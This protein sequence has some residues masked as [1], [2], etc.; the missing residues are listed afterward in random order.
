MARLR[1]RDKEPRKETWGPANLLIYLSVP[2]SY[3]DIPAPK[4]MALEDVCGVGGWDS[5]DD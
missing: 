3:V 5:A 2:S 4:E 1:I